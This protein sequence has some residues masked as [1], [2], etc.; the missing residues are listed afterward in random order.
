MAA[1]YKKNPEGA[2]MAIASTLTAKLSDEALS[3]AV[4]EVPSTTTIAARLERH[5]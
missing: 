3:S 1:L 4:K 2:E 5:R